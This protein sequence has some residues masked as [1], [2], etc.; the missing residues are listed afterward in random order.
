MIFDPAFHLLFG[1][2][3]CFQFKIFIFCRFFVNTHTTFDV[4]V[5]KKYLKNKIFQKIF[6]RQ[7]KLSEKSFWRKKMSEIFFSNFK[8]KNIFKILE[9]IF[10]DFSFLKKQ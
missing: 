6:F 9:N 8:I 2:T 1:K 3:D 7:K 5:L 10:L 4:C